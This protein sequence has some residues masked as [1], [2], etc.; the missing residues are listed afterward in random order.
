MFVQGRD[1]LSSAQISLKFP[2][3]EAREPSHRNPLGSFSNIPH[4]GMLPS[5]KTVCL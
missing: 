5:N 3:A 1:P 4:W 2:A